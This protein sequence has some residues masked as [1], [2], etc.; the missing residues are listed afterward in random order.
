MV[1][2]NTNQHL[3]I[4]RCNDARDCFPDRIKPITNRETIEKAVYKQKNC[5]AED[6]MTPPSKPSVV[7]F[8]HERIDEA[9]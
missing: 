7:V 2:Q 3:A 1:G 9:A 4:Q 8:Q 6:D 5:F